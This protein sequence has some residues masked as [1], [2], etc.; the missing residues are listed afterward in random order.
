[1]KGQRFNAFIT[2]Y[3]MTSGIEERLVED[4]GDGLVKGGGYGAYFHGE[5]REW[6]RTKESAFARAKVMQAAKLKSIDKQRAK[7]AALK[8]E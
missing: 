6:H 4:C 8:F 1:M 5:G 3:A 7:I 2:K